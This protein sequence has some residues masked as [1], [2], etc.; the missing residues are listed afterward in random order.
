MTNKSF[1]C[2]LTSNIM[3]KK[4]NSY[5]TTIIVLLKH[6]EL[7]PTES[8]SLGGPGSP[9]FLLPRSQVSSVQ[10]CRSVMSDSLRPHESQHARPPCP[11]PTPWVHSNSHPSSWWCHPTISSSV[12][13]FSSCPQSLPA[14]ESYPMS[15]LFAWGGQSIGVQLQ[16]HSFQ[17]NPRADLLQNGLVGSPCSP[18]DSQEVKWREGM[19][20][21][22]HIWYILN[23]FFYPGPAFG[24]HEVFENLLNNLVFLP[25]SL[26]C[27]Y[28]LMFH[29][30]C[31]STTFSFT[32]NIL[33]PISS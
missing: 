25:Y 5:H 10:F 28:T 27:H 13:P 11:S 17:R 24:T 9:G 14:S 1:H 31:L 12:I 2:S 32:R 8:L 19:Y 3:G 30:S 7:S 6:C 33:R 16:H 23:I 15:Q 20:A 26:S 22:C 29:S 4:V 21:D 18:R